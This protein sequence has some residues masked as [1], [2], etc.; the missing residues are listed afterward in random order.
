MA[1]RLFLF[2]ISMVSGHDL[3]GSKRFVPEKETGW[4]DRIGPARFAFAEA[5]ENRYGT[6]TLAALKGIAV[7][8]PK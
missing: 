6:R 7:A 8:V 1:F 3:A 5:E 2:L 4:S